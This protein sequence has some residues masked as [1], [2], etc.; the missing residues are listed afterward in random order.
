MIFMFNTYSLVVVVE[1]IVRVDIGVALWCA[2]ATCFCGPMAS[3]GELRSAFFL[4]TSL[5]VLCSLP[6]IICEPH[7]YTFQR[8][9]K[10]LLLPWIAYHSRIVGSRN[11]HIIDHSS[12]NLEV[13]QLLQT[14]KDEGMDVIHFQGDFKDKQ[15]YLS[16]Q[17]KSCSMNCTTLIPL[18]VDEFIVL[19][20][21]SS[22]N[23]HFVTDPLQ[24][25]SALANLP[26]DGHKY[27]FNGSYNGRYLGQDAVSLRPFAALHFGRSKWKCVSKTFFPAATFRSTDQGNH[28]GAVS[29]ACS[30]Q[31]PSWQSRCRD[32]FHLTNL[33]LV[34]FTGSASSFESFHVKMLR[35][36]HAYGRD[37]QV[38][39]GKPCVKGK[40]RHYCNY[41]KQLKQNGVQAMKAQFLKEVDTHR[42]F[43]ND[44][45]AKSLL[46]VV[47]QE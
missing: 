36:A 41:Y 35:G 9:E 37:K 13:L 10:E 22:S 20:S 45:V 18:D 17:M 19:G 16:R 2:I 40:G 38:N 6:C 8:D 5:S 11:L 30:K 21:T 31:S 7:I 44:G 29:E 15:H 1:M 3:V 47:L 34:H 32:C 4:R 33:A 27:K 26:N 39:A 25:H 24:I 46:K 23:T 28:R 42:G 43:Y 14:C 12:T